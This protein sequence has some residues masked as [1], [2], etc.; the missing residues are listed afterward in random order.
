MESMK[1]TVWN[2]QRASNFWMRAPLRDISA[3]IKRSYENSV[4]LWI[5]L[6]SCRSGL[7]FSWRS[8]WLHFDLILHSKTNEK[9]GGSFSRW[10]ECALVM[11][12]RYKCLYLN[13]HDGKQEAGWATFWSCWYRS[14]SCEKQN[15][16]KSSFDYFITWVFSP[17]GW[18]RDAII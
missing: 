12:S 15:D 16:H 6:F 18:H 11:E 17:H 14:K 7:L 2:T 13:G 10:D 9:T 3:K 1:Q 5:S 4:C 8:L